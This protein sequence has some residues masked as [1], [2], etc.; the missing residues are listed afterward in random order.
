VVI[1]AAIKGLRV[2]QCASHLAR[3]KP[4]TIAELYEVIQNIASQMT[5]TEKESK[6]KITSGLKSSNNFQPPRPNNYE[7]RPFTPHNQVNQIENDSNVTAQSEYTHQNQYNQRSQFNET[8]FERENFDTT[9]RGKGKTPLKPKDMYCI[10]HGK[11]AGHTSEMCPKV[12]KSIEEAQKENRAQ[13]Q[14]KTINHVRQEQHSTHQPYYPMHYGHTQAL[15]P[16]PP[17]TY[18]YEPLA[19][20]HPMQNQWRQKSDSPT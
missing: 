18:N 15:L 9:E 12:K 1:I 6:K 19:M 2:S 16:R 17:P 3:E 10:I 5:T 14:S 8:T 13:R 7:R 4:T 11:G 20:Y